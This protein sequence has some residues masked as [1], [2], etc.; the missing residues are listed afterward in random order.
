MDAE[1]E[2][3]H[4]HAVVQ[5]HVLRV[6]CLLIQTRHCPPKTLFATFIAATALGH[7]A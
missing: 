2:E 6:L 3:R 5:S 4:L 1:A 7:P